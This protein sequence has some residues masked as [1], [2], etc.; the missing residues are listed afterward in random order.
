M[1][2]EPQ[3]DPQPDLPLAPPEE[4]APM[5]AEARDA[6]SV[7]DAGEDEHSYELNTA[8]FY[9]IVH[10][11]IIHT[12]VETLSAAKLD[13]SLVEPFLNAARDVCRGDFAQTGRVEIHG[14]TGEAG[15]LEEAEE[16]FVGL[17]VADQDTGAEWL[18]ETWFLSDLVLQTGDAARV[19]EAAR[20][21][22]RSV[23]RLDRWLA[24]HDEQGPG[25]AD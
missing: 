3:H 10:K 15:A 1:A 16:A 12:T 4:Q 23:A 22:E 9:N 21:L 19:R 24:D 20:A 14:V 17:T 8:E 13:W 18:S 6:D 2:D 7:A 11:Q 25:E 5:E